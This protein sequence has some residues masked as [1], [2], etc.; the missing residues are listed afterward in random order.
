MILRVTV[1]TLFFYITLSL[2]FI[3]VISCARPTIGPSKYGKNDPSLTEKPT[4]EPTE[5]PTESPT[6]TPIQIPTGILITTPTAGVDEKPVIA[7]IAEPEPQPT[8]ED[9]G[10]MAYDAPKGIWAIRPGYLGFSIGEMDSTFIDDYFSKEYCDS[11][12]PDPLKNSINFLFSKLDYHEE[13]SDYRS[14]WI[15]MDKTN[16]GLPENFF[17]DP[18][19]RIIFYSEIE[20]D[21]PTKDGSTNSLADPR[22]VAKLNCSKDTETSNY[23]TTTFYIGGNQ[24]YYQNDVGRTYIGPEHSPDRTKKRAYVLIIDFRPMLL[25]SD[26]EGRNLHRTPVYLYEYTFPSDND[27]KDP[28]DIARDALTKMGNPG[29]LTDGI[30]NQEYSEKDGTKIYFNCRLNVSN[31]GFAIG[32]IGSKENELGGLNVRVRYLF[33]ESQHSLDHNF[34]NKPYYSGDIN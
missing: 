27:T 19:M 11:E 21:F 10:K 13:G 23:S 7:T 20:P 30:L 4:E 33:F 16:T 18:I 34:F 15:V 5:S 9:L 17:S 6:E 3:F 28:L 8:F 2:F 29:A 32:A 1:K 26:H 24:N 12:I 14:C 31:P 22:F 25:G